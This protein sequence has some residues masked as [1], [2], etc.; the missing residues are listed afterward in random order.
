MWLTRITQPDDGRTEPQPKAD[1]IPNHLTLIMMLIA[2]TVAL[3]AMNHA[4]PLS[5]NPPKKRV[6][7]LCCSHQTGEVRGSEV[8]CPH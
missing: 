4:R 6:G 7:Q 1:F 5:S 3:C 8:S 2:M